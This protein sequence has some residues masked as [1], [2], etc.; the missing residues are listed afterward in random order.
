MSPQAQQ[1]AIAKACGVKQK[2][3]IMKRGYYYRPNGSG[4]TANPAEAWM[5]SEETARK[6]VY[7][8][9]EP[10]TMHPAPLPDYLNDRNAMA[11]AKKFLNRDQRESFIDELRIILNDLNRDDPTWL[12][13]TP[14]DYTNA[15]PAQEATAFVRALSLW[16][17]EAA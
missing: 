16:V 15:N 10:V 9:D 14:F 1:I 4:Y 3:F 12:G 8:H 5:V 11:Q 7:P 6:H 17:E 2:Y 13:P